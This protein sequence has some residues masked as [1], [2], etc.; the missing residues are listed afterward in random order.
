MVVSSRVPATTSLAP[1][2]LRISLIIQLVQNFFAEDGS[3]QTDVASAAAE[4]PVISNDTCRFFNE[5]G[6]TCCIVLEC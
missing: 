1:Q 4:L 6:A 5:L 2:N 3:Q